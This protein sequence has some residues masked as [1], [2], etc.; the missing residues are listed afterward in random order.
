M[1]NPYNKIYLKKINNNCSKNN[2]STNNQYS[3]SLIMGS[4]NDKIGESWKINQIIGQKPS[5]SKN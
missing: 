4:L 1:Y 5:F 3:T 2:K